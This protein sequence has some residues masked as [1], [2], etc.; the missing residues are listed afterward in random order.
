MKQL[1][2]TKLQLMYFLKNIEKYCRIALSI[3]MRRLI[4][5]NDLNNQK[6]KRRRRRQGL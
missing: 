2:K 3:K 5:R 1:P 4:D 6:Q